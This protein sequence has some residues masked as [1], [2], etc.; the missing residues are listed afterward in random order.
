MSL[1]SQL[2]LFI[3]VGIVYVSFTFIWAWHK[4]RQED[5]LQDEYDDSARG[6]S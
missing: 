2:G 3:A 5:E 4:G 1:S 6:D